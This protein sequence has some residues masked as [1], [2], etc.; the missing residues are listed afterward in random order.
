MFD[1][2]HE[3]NEDWLREEMESVPP[4]IVK[5]KKITRTDIIISAL[6]F[7]TPQTA[8]EIADRIKEPPNAVLGHLASIRKSGRAKRIAVKNGHNQWV[9]I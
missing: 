6:S 4:S 1:R 2:F 3:W 7:D 9:R 8:R 5:P